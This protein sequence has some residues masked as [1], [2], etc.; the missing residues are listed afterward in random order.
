MGFNQSGPWGLADK[1]TV[2]N[3]LSRAPAWEFYCDATLYEIEHLRLERDEIIGYEQKN[4]NYVEGLQTITKA[5][6]AEA[7]QKAKEKAERVR[8]R[9]QAEPGSDLGTGIRGFKYIDEATRKEYFRLKNKM[10]S[11]SKDLQQIHLALAAYERHQIAEEARKAARKE[12]KAKGEVKKVERVFRNLVPSL[13]RQWEDMKRLV[14]ESPLSAPPNIL[15]CEIMDYGYGDRLKDL[16]IQKRW[17]EEHGVEDLPDIPKLRVPEGFV[18]NLEAI[19][20]R[21]LHRLDKLKREHRWKALESRYKELDS[22]SE[23]DRLE[24]KTPPDPK[25]LL[26]YTRTGGS[27][28]VH[29]P[30]GRSRRGSLTTYDR[31]CTVQ[32]N[33][34]ELLPGYPSAMDGWEKVETPEQM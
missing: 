17:L 30:N 34:V 8:F 21:P 25:Q 7:E 3:A 20:G 4:G 23:F 29:N 14:M 27:V 22:I 28:V 16:H 31:G 11:M 10:E 9:K 18:A 2:R 26:T 15:E 1:A 32:V 6:F 19:I 24:G 5:E 12:L 33:R 13:L